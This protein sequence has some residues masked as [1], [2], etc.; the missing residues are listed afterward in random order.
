MVHAR[1]SL[2][3]LHVRWASMGEINPTC[4]ISSRFFGE[5]GCI[6]HGCVVW[7][8]VPLEFCAWISHLLQ[9]LGV[10]DQAVRSLR[11]QADCLA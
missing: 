1:G 9:V 7:I 5:S 10:L 4:V 8:F 3:W 2:E 11:S 6:M